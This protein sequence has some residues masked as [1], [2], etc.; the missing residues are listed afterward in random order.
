MTFPFSSLGPNLVAAFGSP[1]SVYR[2]RRG[3]TTLDANGFTT[4][5]A[6]QKVK[7]KAVVYP[8]TGR[9]VEVLP[10]GKRTEETI[11]VI[12]TTDLRT[13]S[14]GVNPSDQIEYQGKTYEVALLKDWNAN[15]N[16]Y[17]VL[18]TRVNVPG[19]EG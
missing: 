2:V 15:A 10:E 18:A 13:A 4:V 8:A 5:A 11:H 12:S 14:P 19:S 6:P 7:I 17:S 1:A 16:F 9:D 3:H